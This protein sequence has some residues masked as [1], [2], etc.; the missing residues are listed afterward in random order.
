[1]PD[2]MQTHPLCLIYRSA[3]WNEKSKAAHDG[4]LDRLRR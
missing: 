2:N 1:M 4:F 3:G